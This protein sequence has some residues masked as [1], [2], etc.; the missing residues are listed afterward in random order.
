MVNDARPV[1][2]NR[3]PDI[4]IRLRAATNEFHRDAEN[5]LD[6]PASIAGK[7]DYIRL[8]RTLWSFYRPL[9]ARLDTIEGL[10]GALPDWPARHKSQLLAADLASL[11]AGLPHE[12]RATNAA[13]AG[14]DDL[15]AAF[16]ALY[17]VEGATLGGAIVGPSIRATLAGADDAFAFYGCYGAQ[18]GPRWREFIAALALEACEPD[19]RDEIVAAARLTFATFLAHFA[20]ESGAANALREPPA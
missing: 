19:A 11:G 15:A 17:V 1:P 3:T 2:S 13:L 18:I 5:A 4:L 9:E 20:R 8:L 10:A 6:L 12:N 16:G 14:V 7:A